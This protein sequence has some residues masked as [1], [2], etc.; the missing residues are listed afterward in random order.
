MYYHFFTGE[1]NYS[2]AFLE[3]LEEVADLEVHVIVFGLARKQDKSVVYAEKLSCRIKYLTKPG[4]LYFVLRHIFN[5]EWIY[6]HY[7]A[8]DPTLLFWAL[9]KKLIRR[10]TWIVWGND[11]YSYYKRNKNLKTKVYERL[12]NIIIPH[13]T[14]IAAFVEEDFDLIKKLYKCEA[15]YCPILYPIPVN[16]AHLDKFRNKIKSEGITF[17][18]GNSGDSSNRH[19]EMIDSLSR[20]Q[21]E[22]IIIKCPLSYGG[23]LDYKKAVINYGKEIFGNKFI[24]ITQF[25]NAD[26]YAQL[27]SS[28]DVALM[29]HK[30]QQG[31]GN[32]L[33]LIYLGAKV[34][35]RSDITSFYFFKRND[36]EVFDIQTIHSN[37]FGDV[38]SPPNNPEHSMHMVSE[39]LSEDTCK[40]RWRNLFNRH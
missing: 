25:M 21:N 18:I 22:N 19:I 2:K 8:Y 40:L 12:R 37:G 11:I 36:I 23:S 26:D 39:L 1:S 6:L 27:L 30:R 17:L 9:N 38:I 4:D 20:F 35:L 16:R 10:S 31:L 32:I 14:E 5:A 13:F 24:P 34:Y 3:L 15:R 28:I 7:L 33:A 29:N